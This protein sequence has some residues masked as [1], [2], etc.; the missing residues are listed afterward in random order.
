MKAFSFKCLLSAILVT[1]LLSTIVLPLFAVE[2]EY[3]YVKDRE[4]LLTDAERRS[5]NAV[6]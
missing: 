6:A 4:A 1:L 3:E 5:V 2:T